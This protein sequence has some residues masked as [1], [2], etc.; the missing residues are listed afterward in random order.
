[1]ANFF[2]SIGRVKEYA[3]WFNIID[4]SRS[5][6]RS[7]CGNG[8]GF[9]SEVGFYYRKRKD[10]M[11]NNRTIETKRQNPRD[12]GEVKANRGEIKKESTKG[13]KRGFDAYTT[14]LG[15]CLFVQ[16]TCRQPMTHAGSIL[17]RIADLSCNDAE[18]A[19]TTAWAKAW[20]SQQKL[21]VGGE[22]DDW[23]EGSECF[24]KRAPQSKCEAQ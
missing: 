17:T 21:M 3:E 4:R 10:R 18:R 5:C 15:L 12:G 1:M 24:P 2:R 23:L 22:D 6:Q 11:R 9:D 13:R 20:W 14:A 19:D 7:A 8:F 16:S